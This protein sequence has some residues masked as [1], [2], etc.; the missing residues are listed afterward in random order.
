MPWRLLLQQARTNCA[1][2]AAAAWSVAACSAGALSFATDGK[3]SSRRSDALH[4]IWNPIFDQQSLFSKTIAHCSGEEGL[5]KVH[6]ENRRL[7]VT[8][9]KVKSGESASLRFDFPH[10]RWEVLPAG[11]AESPAPTFH[12][13]GQSH[14]VC[15]KSIRGHREYVFEFLMPPKYTEKEFK[16]RQAAVWYHGSPGTKFM[17]EN[18]YCAA[19][20]FRVPGKGGDKHDMHQHTV[21][22]FFVVLDLPSCLDVYVP[23]SDI[24][25]PSADRRVHH[26][27]YLCTLDCPDVS[28]S[29]RYFEEDGSGGFVDGK[30]KLGPAVHGVCNPRPE[31]FRE[32]YIDLK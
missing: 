13:A 2:R 17:F 24:D 28:T 4:R 20:D 29:W 16:Q 30:P 1:S 11:T 12:F 21:D 32:Y 25:L 14:V 8:E 27:R 26:V 18:E 5:G 23:Q 9:V 3:T 15:P 22:H 10:L 6:F 19:F 31:E 7:R